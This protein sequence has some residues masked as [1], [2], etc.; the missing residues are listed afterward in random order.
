[1]SKIKINLWKVGFSTVQLSL[2]V[3][4]LVVIEM[5]YA[6]YCTESFC[7]EYT[8]SYSK[9]CPAIT[10]N[11]T[12]T[13]YRK[14]LDPEVCNCC[15]YCFDYLKEGDDC[16]AAS[17]EKPLEMCGPQLMCV[18]ENIESD[19]GKCHK[20]IQTNYTVFIKYFI[21]LIFMDGL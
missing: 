20:S 10:N 9:P 17:H 11:C 7:E 12:K 16:T 1:M 15:E 5:A 13:G 21:I 6:F 4:F 14:Y 3:L 19:K 18:L 2:V 8:A